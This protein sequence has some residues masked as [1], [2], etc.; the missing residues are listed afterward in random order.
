[1]NDEW[2]DDPSSTIRRVLITSDTVKVDPE[3]SFRSKK[4]A[5]ILLQVVVSARDDQAK[6]VRDGVLTLVQVLSEFSLD[7]LLETGVSYCAGDPAACVVIQDRIYES[8]HRAGLLEAGRFVD[9][10]SQEL[11]P[12][13]YAENLRFE[14]EVIVRR[15]HPEL[16]DDH[17]SFTGRKA[18]SPFSDRWFEQEW[19]RTK[20]AIAQLLPAEWERD[21]RLIPVRIHREAMTAHAISPAPD[22]SEVFLPTPLQ[23]AILKALENRALT[24]GQLAE[25]VCDGDSSRLY[26][27]KGRLRNLQELQDLGLVK[28]ERGK[29]YYRPDAPPP[30]AIKLSRRV[31]PTNPQADT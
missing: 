7:A 19:P 2:D 18:R 12:A 26:K 3:T 22:E 11:D 20:L 21:F 9:M 17:N 4:L 31:H 24:K 15:I 13:A 14:R 30:T 29:G 1:M 25:V 6:H 5:D 10:L 28:N 23:A 27:P 8:A 16:F